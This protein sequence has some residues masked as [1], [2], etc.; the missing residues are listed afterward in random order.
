MRR[1]KG[2]R[3]AGVRWR[4]EEKQGRECEEEEVWSGRR[5]E[6]EVGGRGEEQKLVTRKGTITEVR[7]Y[8]LA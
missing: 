6:E 2:R 8:I 1:V 7:S 5:R 3:M 4:K